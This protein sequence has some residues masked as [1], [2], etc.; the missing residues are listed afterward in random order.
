MTLHDA[1]GAAGAGTPDD[2]RRTGAAT[3]V[4]VVGLGYVG[5]PTA[6]A[7]A[8]A[9]MTVHGVDVSQKRLEDIAAGTVDLAPADAQRLQA[10]HGRHLQCGTDVRVLDSADVIVVCVP[11][12]TTPDHRPDLGPLRAA[13]RSVVRRAR[14]GHL[15]VLT[16]TTYVGCTRELL[17]EPLARRGLVAGRDVA[18]CF[19][20]ERI[21]PGNATHALEDVPRV[22]GGATAHCAEH[23]AAVLRA[24]SPVHRVSSLE[25]AEL[26][27]LH[28]NTF[29]A[30]NIAYAFDLSRA[31]SEYG[32]D[33]REVIDAAASKPFGFMPFFPGP[34]VGGHC[35][36]CD[37][38]YLEKP[39]ADRGVNLP[40]VAEAMR[41]IAARPAGVV[42]A[43]AA[44]LERRGRDLAGA[45]VLVVGAA[46]KANV[47]DVRESP[48]VEIIGRLHAEG[49]L[50]DYHDRMV[51]TLEMPGGGGLVSV[52]DPDPAAYDLVIV[53]VVH[54]DGRT[55]WSTPGTPVL[56]YTRGPAAV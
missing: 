54:D 25:A 3:S 10:F 44:T 33:V 29:R 24:V 22:L 8:G 46:Y 13:C 55:S 1:V 40:V 43:A 27:K 23:A 50:V 2:L 15:V 52:V 34:G 41:S 35:I 51:P 56:D 16:S 6:L 38:H 45:H 28:E 31:A 30:V 5:L 4:A 12:P 14:P 11:T 47:A 7:F 37:P 49:A 18:V 9:G 53:A 17:V 32:L 20:P 48:A 42:R 39:L 21:D 19:A 26:V 36:P